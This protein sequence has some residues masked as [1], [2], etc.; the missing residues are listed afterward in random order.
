[1]NWIERT[2]FA[3]AIAAAAAAGGRSGSAAADVLAA[4][5]W[6]NRPVLVF[7]PEGDARLHEQAGRFAAEQGKKRERDI[8]LIEIVGGSARADGQA[9]PYARTLRRRFGVEDAEFAVILVGKDGT[10]KMR[11][12]EVTEP[13]AFYDLIDTMPMRHQEMR[14]AE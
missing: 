10:E 6:K 1:M 11:V 2:L 14:R 3:T 8:V 4:Y 13:Y 5:R 9:A 12:G 7:A